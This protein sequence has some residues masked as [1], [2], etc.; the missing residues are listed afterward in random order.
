MEVSERHPLVFC[1]YVRHEILFHAKYNGSV[2]ICRKEVDDAPVRDIWFRYFHKKYRHV[3]MLL[4]K[5]PP[6]SD[7]FTKFPA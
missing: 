4:Q 3:P 7:A 2:I 5:G 1:K 6:Y